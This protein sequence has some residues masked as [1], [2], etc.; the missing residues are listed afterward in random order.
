MKKTKTVKAK[1]IAKPKTTVVP[2]PPKREVVV[3]VKDMN[4]F[5]LFLTQ[6]E[7]GAK[8]LDI[9]QVKEVLS[10]VV[11]VIKLYPVNAIELLCKAAMGR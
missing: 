5:A 4:D 2:V 3:E 9:A 1:K 11:N 10:C 7:G 8:N 6:M